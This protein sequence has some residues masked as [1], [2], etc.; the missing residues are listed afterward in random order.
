[1]A[2]TGAEA[3]FVDTNI[4]VHANDEDSAFHEAAQ[5]RLRD[6]DAA[7]HELW[8][9]RQVL[10]EY[11]VVVSR[12]MN[13]R[14][15]FDAVA[16]AADLDRLEA[17][18]RVGDEDARITLTL[19]RL[20]QSHAVK[21]KPIHDANI[22]ATMLVHRVGKLLTQNESDFARYVPA[23]EILPLRESPASP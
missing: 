7:G 6:L 22:V 3:V 11:A 20:I 4:L 14:N 19:K 23:I 21:G 12:K 18:Y 2:T 13:E 16:L 17:E 5:Q 8:I 10:R 9:S 15:A 1:M